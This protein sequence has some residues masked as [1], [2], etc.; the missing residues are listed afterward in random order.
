M[1]IKN[2]CSVLLLI[3]IIAFNPTNDLFSKHTTT[4]YQTSSCDP[5]EDLNVIQFGEMLN[6]NWHDPSYTGVEEYEI[7]ILINGV[8]YSTYYTNDF[9]FQILLCDL[10][11]NPGDIITIEVRKICE[12]GTTSPPTII[13]GGVCNES[14]SREESKP[15]FRKINP[16]PNVSLLWRKYILCAISIIK[17]WLK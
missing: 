8:L 15:S 2:L 1:T 11:L 6:I 3:G 9:E 5:V 14:D 13:E 12:D 4:F 16:I 17:D 10:K 7:S